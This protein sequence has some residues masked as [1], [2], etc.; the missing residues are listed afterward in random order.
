MPLRHRE[1]RPG[2]HRRLPQE[3]RHLVLHARGP[4]RARPEAPAGEARRVPQPASRRR[5]DAG[6]AGLPAPRSR[7]RATSADRRRLPGRVA[8]RQGRP[9]GHN[10]QR[11]PHDRGDL[12]QARHRPPAAERPARGRHRGPL[13]R[14]RPPRPPRPPEHA[15]HP[16]TPGRPGRPGRPP[17]QPH[18]GPSGARLPHVRADVGGQAAPPRLQPGPPRRAG[19]RAASSGGRLDGRPRRALAT[20]GRASR[21]GRLDGRAGRLLSGQ[22][23][24]PRAVPAAAPRGV[25]RAAPWRGGRPAMGRRRPRRAASP[26]HAADR[27]AGLA[28]GARRRP[29][30]GERRP[31]DHPRRGDDRGAA[32]S[33]TAPGGPPGLAGADMAGP[34][35][36]VP[37]S[38]RPPTG[39]RHGQQRLPAA[40]PGGRPP[41]HPP[42][43]PAA[44]R[45]EPRAAGRRP[46]EGRV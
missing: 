39:P 22:H 24:R 35:A 16:A 18:V 31:H 23:R 19:A 36:R 7:P 32:R 37:C 40:R 33:P 11:L 10:P 43:R 27:A 21:G 46:A 5:R 34:R 41:A 17:A 13:R 20:D 26:H 9:A 12:P 42:A 28:H 14:H 3:A 8:R 15:A 1:G 6:V 4:G 44:H 38:G 30:D 45:R 29:E 2:S 25:P